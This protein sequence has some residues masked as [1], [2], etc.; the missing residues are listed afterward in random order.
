MATRRRPRWN[1]RRVTR[2]AALGA[3]AV[4]ITLL[5]GAA[6]PDLPAVARLSLGTAYAGLVYLALALMIGPVNLLRNQP[7]PV[8]SNLRRDIGIWAGI[9]GLVHTV[10]GLQVHFGGD[11]VR[12]FVHPDGAAG[13][14]PIRYDAFGLANHTGLVAALVLLVLLALSNNVSLRRLGARR[15]KS[16]QRWAYVG[17]GLV[18]L[19]GLLYQLLERRTLALVVIFLSVVL[20]AAGIQALGISMRRQVPLA[21]RS[22]RA[23]GLR[24]RHQDP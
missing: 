20:V 11:F 18:L 8:S 4:V 10:L 24:R 22:A 5:F 17:A 9:F 1:S 23:V 14:V 3:G 19:H 12:Y 2:H 13:I 7:N 16:A 21:D 6:D 15:W